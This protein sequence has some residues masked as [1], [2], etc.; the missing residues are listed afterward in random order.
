MATLT[1]SRP[2]EKQKL[3]LTADKKYIAFGGSRGGG[4]SFAVRMKAI[5]LCLNYKG[6]KVM[7]VRKTYP[8]LTENH[9]KPLVET[10]RCY[11]P[12]KEQRL[13]AYNDSKK[14]ITF[15]NGSTILFKYCDTDKDAE[16]FQGTE[17]DVLFID[18]ATHQSE[19]RF[20]KLIACVRGVNDF[21]KRIYLTCNPGGV[22]HQWVK[23]LFIDRKYQPG[24]NA[25]EYM[26]IKSSVFDNKALLESN[27]DYVKQLESLPP[28]LKR[29][30]LD[31]DFRYI[32]NTCTTKYGVRDRVCPGICTKVPILAA[33]FSR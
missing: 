5:L 25:D 9:I 1:L 28:K 31:G 33:D 6:I 13:A 2:S 29:A 32:R 8:E 18:E 15:P 26:F 12:D 7:V 19:E 14:E 24:E 22:G 11:H 27:P 3:F 23:R 21:P 20:K 16:R 30:W 10:L 4:K 17:I